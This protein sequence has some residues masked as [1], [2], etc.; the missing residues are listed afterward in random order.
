MK[1]LV[2]S[3]IH[4]NLPALEKVESFALQADRIICL[5]DIVGYNAFPNE[6][7][8]WLQDHEAECVKGNHDQAALDAKAEWFNDAAAQ[9]IKWTQKELTPKSRQFLNDL[10]LQ[11]RVEEKEITLLAL[12]GSPRDPL[13]EYVFPDDQVQVPEGVD[14]LALGHTHLPFIRKV[15]PKNAKKNANGQDSKKT[16]KN[17]DPADKSQKSAPSVKTVTI[18]NPGS[19]GQPRDGDPRL[20]FAWVQLPQMSVQIK[21][22]EYPVGQTAAANQKAGLPQRFSQRLFEG[23]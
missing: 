17:K 14:I 6:C 20:S 2:L 5:G 19:V 3:D 23:T 12:H 10:P 4:A 8:G 15:E 1:L 18:F 13:H 22:L 21:R 9:A 11:I 7:I 16:G